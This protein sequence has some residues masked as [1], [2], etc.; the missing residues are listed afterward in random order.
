MT[1]GPENLTER[2]TSGDWDPDPGE[3]EY[4]RSAIDGQ[5]GWKVR[6]D[7]VEWIRL[8]R[9]FEEILKR[10]GGDWLPELEHRQITPANIAQVCF[11]A[12][13]K[14][15]FFLGLHENARRDWNNLHE[16]QRKE[17]IAKGPPPIVMSKAEFQK[18][19]PT[20]QQKLRGEAKRRQGTRMLVYNSIK[21]AIQGN[22]GK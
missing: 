22:P 17:W 2:D 15:C 5:L 21:L 12:D 3:R 16:E 14:L 6:R 11:E 13:K 9:A 8:D 20:E 7:G 19:T 10:P 1:F 18:L 4:F